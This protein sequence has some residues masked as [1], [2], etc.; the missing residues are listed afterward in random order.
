MI[1]KL[2]ILLIAIKKEKFTFQSSFH[3]FDIKDYVKIGIF[4][5]F[6]TNRNL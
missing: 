4:D 5:R 1:E 6:T 3:I 2:F